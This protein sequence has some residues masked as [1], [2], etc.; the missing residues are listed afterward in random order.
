MLKESI[1]VDTCLDCLLCH[2]YELKFKGNSMRDA[3]IS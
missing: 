3:K 1:Y 2:A